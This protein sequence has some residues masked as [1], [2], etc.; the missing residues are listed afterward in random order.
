MRPSFRK[1]FPIVSV[2]QETAGYESIRKIN[3]LLSSKKRT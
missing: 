2:E 3:V 1:K